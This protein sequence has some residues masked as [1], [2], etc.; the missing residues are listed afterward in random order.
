[1]V[2]GDVND[3]A[4]ELQANAL[5]R[6]DSIEE[7]VAHRNRALELAQQGLE[8]LAQ[9]E[10]AAKRAAPQEYCAGFIDA[11]VRDR[12]YDL[13]TKGNIDRV[14]KLVQKHVDEHAWASLK[15]LSGLRNIMDATM[16]EEM[17]KQLAKEPPPFTL[18]NVMATFANLAA[19]AP[20]IFERSLLAVF[21]RL[22]TRDYKTNSAF[23]I[24]PRII[25]THMLDYYGFPSHK[26]ELMA[27]LDRI[28]H[29]LDGKQPP[30][31]GNAADAIEVAYR[32][33]QDT[34]TTEYFEA[35]MF[36]GNGNLHLKFRRL[37]LLERANDII[38]CHYPTRLPDD[39]K[40]P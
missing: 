26:R 15:R 4:D 25:L 20:A 30:E 40:K 6:R 28:F 1:M 23:K 35:R 22:N 16:H 18:D 7:L 3:Y 11:L 13:Q 39:T 38:S 33:A 12:L 21:K 8:L 9:A 37:D 10:T 19:Q 14:M 34:C 24:G 36:R 29:T 31:A 5:A 27:D 32:A 17:A 2:H